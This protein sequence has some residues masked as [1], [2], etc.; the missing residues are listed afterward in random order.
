M[1]GHVIEHDIVTLVALGEI[2]FGV[3]NYVI[4]PERLDQLGVA[5]AAN[6]GHVCAV[7]FCNLN[8]ERANTAG[9]A[10]DQDLLSGLNFALVAN[11]LERGNSRD[12]DRSCLLKSDSGRLQSDRSGC[13]PAQILSE[14][15]GASAK[16][17]IARFVLRN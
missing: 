7:G 16:H 14:R 12:V 11:G 2:L 5:S 4:S 6:A 1:I 13:A 8:R 3:I 10:V 15:A 9:C 17:L